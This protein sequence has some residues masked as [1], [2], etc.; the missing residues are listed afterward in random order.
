[1]KDPTMTSPSELSAVHRALQLLLLA[2]NWL[3]RA[4][5]T[6]QPAAA[7]AARLYVA[8]AFFLSGLTKVQDWGVTVDLFTYEYQVPLLP[9]E[10][11]AVMGTAGELGLPVLLVLGLGGRFA[12]LGLSFVNAVAVISLMEIAPAALEQHFS[13]GLL[14]AALAIFGNGPWAVDRWLTLKT[15]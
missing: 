9:P 10:L 15:E 4:M 1:M 5:N 6:L 8:K 14:L 7:L 11:A 12:P 13:W 3:D 2:R